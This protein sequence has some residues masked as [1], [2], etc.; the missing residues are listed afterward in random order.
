[1]EGEGTGQKYYFGND[2]AHKRMFVRPADATEFLKL[3][4]L[5]R[6]A[7]EVPQKTADKPQLAGVMEG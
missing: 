4:N 6:V 3:N 2:Q 1:M 5:F 7:P